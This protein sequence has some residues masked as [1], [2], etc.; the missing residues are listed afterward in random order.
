M[1]TPIPLINYYKLNDHRIQHDCIIEHAKEKVQ[2]VAIPHQHISFITIL[3]K[4]I[5][6]KSQTYSQFCFNHAWFLF[7]PGVISPYA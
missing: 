2:G 3:Y 1:I 7:A 4:L 6:E 5:E